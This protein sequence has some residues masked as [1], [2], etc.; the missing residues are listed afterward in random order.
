MT[1]TNR[2]RVYVQVPQAYA[3]LVHAG[4]GGRIELS[5]ASGSAFPGES[6]QHLALDRF[7]HP[8]AADPA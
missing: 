2:L 1:A 5:R 7:H 3:D 8:H 6:G 4:D